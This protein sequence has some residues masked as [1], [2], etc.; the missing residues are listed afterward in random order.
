MPTLTLMLDRKTVQVYDLD[1]PVI[2]VGRVP[3]MDIVIDNVSV[4]RRQAEIQQEG[5]GWV[6]RDIG[7]SNGTFVNGERLT[8]D[9][10]L[11]PGDEI[12]I[13][14]YSL[15][16][17]HVPSGAAPAPARPSPAAQSDATMYLKPDEV[18]QLQKTAAQKRQAHVLWEAAGRRGIHYLPAAAAAVLIGTSERCDLRVPKG[19]KQHVLVVRGSQG[20]EVRNLSFWRRMRV[21]GRATS[22]A[23]LAS[24][25]VVEIGGVKLTFM[26]EVR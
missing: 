5:E 8:G 9:R 2:R 24:G 19:P 13:G 14:K 25:D 20:F 26:D 10:S 17:E 18:A 12:A 22:R 11:R 16:F 23:G 3:E 6:V 21:N 7:S 1:R 4:S 15:F